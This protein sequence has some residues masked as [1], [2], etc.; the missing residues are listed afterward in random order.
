M[1]LGLSVL[2]P[3]TAHT[4]T[5]IFLH[6]RGDTARNLADTLFWSRDSYRRSLK[7][8][9]PSVRWVFPQ[10]ELRPCERDHPSSPISSSPSPAKGGG[11][12]GG[13]EEEVEEQEYEEEEE[14]EQC[15]QWFDVWNP[16]DYS[17]REELQAPGLRDSVLSVRRLV[18]REARAVGGLSRVVLA[19]ISQGAATAVHVL[20]NMP[21]EGTQIAP[22]E[23]M[24]VDEEEEEEDDD[25]SNEK[26]STTTT[27]TTTTTM[28][29]AR[30]AAFVGFACHM[31]FPGGTLAETRE[32]LG[33]PPSAAEDPDPDPAEV[34]DEPRPSDEVVR[35]TPAF[36][37]HCADDAVV[38]VEYG[39]QLAAQLRDLGVRDVVWREYADG[40]HWLNSPRGVDDLVEFLRAQGLPAALPP[41]PYMGSISMSPD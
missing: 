35:R 1:E 18:A 41:R 33:L 40:G 37:A 26:T 6:D 39:K 10:S 19:G 15:S 34:Y 31:P 23:M 12:G 3:I 29:P 9:F 25:G 30:L 27:T 38:F 32:I 28:P 21:L 4:H 7:D 22:S 20:L 17:D 5:I 8:I 13:G 11:G 2:P 36:L 24:A 14:E 16:L